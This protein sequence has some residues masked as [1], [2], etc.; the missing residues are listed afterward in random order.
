MHGNANGGILWKS[1]R[2][3]YQ[4]YIR[5]KVIIWV[6]CCILFV[7]SR[8][9]YPFDL[10]QDEGRWGL[11]GQA[12]SLNSSQ[13]LVDFQV[14]KPVE[15]QPKSTGCS[16]VLLLMDHQFAYSYGHPFVGEAKLKSLSTPCLSKE[17]IELNLLL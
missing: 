2:L 14:Y 12:Q 6:I 16:Q 3:P 4:Y 8:C 13:V 15:F 5:V 11:R 9:Y 10:L 1:V 7:L 17:R